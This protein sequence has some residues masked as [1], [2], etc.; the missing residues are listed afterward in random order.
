MSSR[1]LSTGSRKN[2]KKCYKLAF[3]ILPYFVISSQ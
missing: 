2:N 1:G 3:F